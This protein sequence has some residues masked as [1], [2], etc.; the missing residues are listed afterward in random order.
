[1][2][3]YAKVCSHLIWCS[4]RLG[5]GEAQ[6]QQQDRFPDPVPSSFLNHLVAFKD[7]TWALRMFRLDMTQRPRME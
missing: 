2:G 6:A 7:T 3:R 4:Q 1:M 5:M